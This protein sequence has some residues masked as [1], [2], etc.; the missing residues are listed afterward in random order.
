MHWTIA[1]LYLLVG[2]ARISETDLMLLP[3]STRIGMK[4]IS[5]YD[6]HM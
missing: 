1:L 5:H 4:E 6:H 2:L 3:E